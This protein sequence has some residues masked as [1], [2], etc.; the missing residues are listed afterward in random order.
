ML[1]KY[2]LGVALSVAVALAQI[3][4]FS[5]ILGALGK[6]LGLLTDSA[7]NA[8]VAVSIAS[9]VLNPLIYR[10]VGPVER[11]VDARPRLREMINPTSAARPSA[12]GREIPAA[13]D[14]AR[15]AVIVGYG[16][17]GRTLARLLRDNGIESTVV[18]L[19]MDTVRQLHDEGAAAVYGEASHRETLTAAGVAEANSLILS[20]AG[21]ENSAEVIRIARELNPMVHILARTSQL[22]DRTALQK[23]GADSVYSGEGELAFA[24]AEDILNRLGAT[25]ERIARERDRVRADLSG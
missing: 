17:T 15:R 1:M 6:E 8:I 11:W 24:L 20:A 19:N 23:A 25:P 5:F 16:P 10:A 9:I 4:E 2:P 7:M 22:R 18:E 3:G 12:V 13:P 14:P 21:M